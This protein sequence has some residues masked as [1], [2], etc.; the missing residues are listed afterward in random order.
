[1]ICVSE[2][3]FNYQFK[4]QK[5]HQVNNMYPYIFLLRLIHQPATATAQPGSH[6]NHA[7]TADVVGS[8]RSRGVLESCRP[9]QQLLLIRMY[10]DER[11]NLLLQSANRVPRIDLEWIP[12][13]SVLD[14]YL[15]RVVTRRAIEVTLAITYCVSTK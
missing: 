4:Q 9:H 6:G 8:N 2:P 10:S 5:E 15:D 12:S 11:L 7:A 1:M 14:G 13:A 3:Q